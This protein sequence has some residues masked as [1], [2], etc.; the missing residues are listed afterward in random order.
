MY[1]SHESVQVSV[2]NV[3]HYVAGKSCLPILFFKVLFNDFSLTN[4]F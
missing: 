2:D 4:N 3:A 1:F